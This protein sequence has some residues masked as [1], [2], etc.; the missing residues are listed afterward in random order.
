VSILKELPHKNIVYLKDVYCTKQTVKLVFEFVESDLKKF[1]KKMG[2][3]LKPGI[4]KDFTRQL[5]E[6]MTFC[7]MHRIIH[8]DLK[9]QNLLI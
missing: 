4:V 6:G 5:L 2:G 3:G 8:R 1:M 7:H 9:P